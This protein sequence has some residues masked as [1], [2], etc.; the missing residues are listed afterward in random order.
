MVTTSLERQQ[1]FYQEEG[2]NGE[3]VTTTPVV[4]T[5]P[6]VF[7]PVSKATDI[8]LLYTL[9]PLPCEIK[10]SYTTLLSLRSVEIFAQKH[11][12]QSVPCLW[13]D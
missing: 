3:G 13:V 4:R 8:A 11:R 7:T 1:Q 12:F 2:D 9:N 6:A 5:V 10:L